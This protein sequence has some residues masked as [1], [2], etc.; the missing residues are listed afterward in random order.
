MGA[1]ILQD[2]VIVFVVAAAATILFYRAKLPLV[3]GYLLAGF[4][5]GPYTPWS[6]I[7]NHESIDS[8]AQLGLILLMFAVGLEFNFR[9]LKKIGL[10]ALVATPLEVGIMLALGM[11][12]A[13][14]FGW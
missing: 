8:L 2:L 3:L 14:A 6:L 4:A 13:R 10:I 7:S 12:V 11:G 9:K 5:V 1:P